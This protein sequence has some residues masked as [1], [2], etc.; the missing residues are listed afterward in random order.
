MTENNLVTKVSPN[1]RRATH[2][3]YQ[4]KLRNIGF[5]YAAIV[6]YRKNFTRVTSSRDLH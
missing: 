3:S 2:L 6:L 4:R 1:E 5:A